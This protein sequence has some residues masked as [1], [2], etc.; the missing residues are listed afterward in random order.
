MLG[1][2]WAVL[3]EWIPVDT[4]R[5]FARHSIAA[6]GALLAFGVPAHVA[7]FV[8]PKIAE[9]VEWFDIVLI[10]VVLFVLG[11]LINKNAS[12]NGCSRLAIKDLPPTYQQNE[13]V[14]DLTTQDAKMCNR[15]EDFG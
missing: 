11:A 8:V 12:T 1:K 7:A 13:Q 5:L 6:T 10:A 9:F 2:V 14:T 3:R 4:L 15:Q